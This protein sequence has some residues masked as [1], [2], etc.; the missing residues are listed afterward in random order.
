MRS[1]ERGTWNAEVGTKSR[2]RLRSRA[3]PDVTRS[4]FRLP[5]LLAGAV[6]LA[7]LPLP[8]GAQPPDSLPTDTHSPVVVT[9]VRLPTPRELGRRLARPTPTLLA[10][11]PDT[12]AL[13]GAAQHR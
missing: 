5:R 11:D 4:A 8:A 10:A 3:R 9:A 7:L 12:P 2:G 13:P 6:T 1:T